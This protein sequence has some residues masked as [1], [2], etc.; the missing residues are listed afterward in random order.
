M[1]PGVSMG[2][3]SQVCAHKRNRSVEGFADRVLSAAMGGQGRLGCRLH[4]KPARGKMGGDLLFIQCLVVCGLVLGQLWVTELLAM[5]T[6][7]E[8][9]RRAL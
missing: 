5:Q 1:P 4:E 7:G 6:F 2:F 8:I 3:F 9:V